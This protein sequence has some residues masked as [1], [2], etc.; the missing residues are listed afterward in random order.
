M[1]ENQPCSAVNNTACSEKKREY[2]IWF[3]RADEKHKTFTQR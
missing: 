3:E 1:S 2:W